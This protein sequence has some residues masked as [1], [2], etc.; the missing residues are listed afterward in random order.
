MI[1]R[2]SAALPA[3]ILSL[4]DV[5]MSTTPT[6]RRGFTLVEFLV[7]IAVVAILS[8]IAMPNLRSS[9]NTANES[10]AIRSLRTLTIDEAAYR[11][12]NS[13]YADLSTLLAVNLV[14]ISLGSATGASSAKSGYYF[15]IVNPG[16]SEFFINAIPANPTSRDRRFYTDQ[17]GVIFVGD[18]TANSPTANSSGVA[19]A[20][21]GPAGN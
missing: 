6:R 3:G 20:G 12:R 4:E 16:P 13:S 19:P 7:A 8:A 10:S 1:H 15:Q 17:A 5:R 14:D 2:F 11:T 18:W 9:T 21:F